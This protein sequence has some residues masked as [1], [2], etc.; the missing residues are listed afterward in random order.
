MEVV[1]VIL[2]VNI[3]FLDDFGVSVVKVGVRY[4]FVLLLLN[5]RLLLSVMVL[6]VVF[7]RVIDKL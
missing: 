6:L 4:L 2:R 1:F 3:I 5:N 7:V